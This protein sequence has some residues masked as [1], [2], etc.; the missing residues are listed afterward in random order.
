MVNNNFALIE[1]LGFENLIKPDLT[2]PEIKHES[3]KDYHWPNGSALA[4]SAID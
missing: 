1:M 2:K 4:L 3:L